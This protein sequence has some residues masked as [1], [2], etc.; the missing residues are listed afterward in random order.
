[1]YLTKTRVTLRRIFR[2]VILDLAILIS[3]LFSKKNGYVRCI[4][5]HNV[6]DLEVDKFKSL[7]VYLLKNHRF[8]TTDELVSIIKNNITVEE[9][10]I[11]LSFDDGLENLVKNAVPILNTYD[12]PSTV[13]VNSAIINASSS[14]KKSWDEVVRY[15]SSQPVMD[16]DSL[17]QSKMEIGNH[18]R[19]H[20]NLSNISNNVDLLE[21]EVIGCKNDIEKNMLTRCKYFAWPFGAMKFIDDHS[22]EFVKQCGH[23]AIFSGVR[24]DVII[25]KT[26]QYLI[27]RNQ[28]ELYWK[29]S[30]IHFFA[31]GG[32]NQFKRELS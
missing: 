12:I 3:H 31:N 26:S 6:Q 27:P 30:H 25:G 18:T 4:Y 1:M 8:I 9:N 15:P 11:H 20:C 10:L 28:V 24:G 2:S 19:H 16:W 17:K 29:M 21:S 22:I 5:L 14:V 13:F 23:E 7:I 32:F